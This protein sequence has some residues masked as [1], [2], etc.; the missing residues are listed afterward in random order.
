MTITPYPSP[1]FGPRRGGA[2]PDMVVLHYTAMD[3]AAAA[4]DRLCC[5]DHEVSA[6]YLI[7]ETG[8]AF[9]LV[10]ED[11]RAWHAGAG[12]W[13]AVSDVNSHS[14]GIELANTGF[15][16]FP[17]PQMAALE[18]LLEGIMRRWAIP[19]MRVI[20]H[21]DMAPGRKVDPG[22]RFDWFRLAMAGLSIWPSGPPKRICE[23]SLVEALRRLGMTAECDEA[24]LLAAFRM[25]YRP[26]VKGPSDAV[27]IAMAQDLADRFPVDQPLLTS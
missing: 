12:C 4:L 8:E 2:Q 16:P 7:S 15:A 18:E 1:N 23:I 17:E 13:G 21:S 9:Q 11:Q 5:P 3:S 24:T 10:N 22:V 19:P 25:R 20:G 14:I 6:H 26:W 27:D